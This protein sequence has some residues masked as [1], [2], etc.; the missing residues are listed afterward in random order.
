MDIWNDSLFS[1]GQA[2]HTSWLR[3]YPFSYHNGLFTLSNNLAHLFTKLQAKE[4]TAKRELTN[5]QN[6]LPAYF[7]LQL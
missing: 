6:L 4:A 3:K 7:L 2:K 5:V 1:Q